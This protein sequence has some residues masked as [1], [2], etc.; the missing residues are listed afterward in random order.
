MILLIPVLILNLIIILNQ[1]V[2][3]L[4]IWCFVF[5]HF[6]SIEVRTDQKKDRLAHIMAYGT[7]PTKMTFK[8]SEYSSTPREL[9]RFD[10]CM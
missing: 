4:F 6:I 10:E 9:D 3:Q 1:R 8:T 7:D 2:Y 5:R